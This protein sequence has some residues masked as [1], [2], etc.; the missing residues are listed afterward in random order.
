MSRSCTFCGLD[1]ERHEPVYLEERANGGRKDAGAF[2]NYACLDAYI[3]EADLTIGACCY[4][5]P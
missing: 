3:D 1:V 5:E 4:W 2:C